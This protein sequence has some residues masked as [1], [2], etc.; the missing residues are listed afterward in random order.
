M[1]EFVCIDC[2][3]C[4][5]EFSTNED[6]QITTGIFVCSDCKENESKMKCDYCGGYFDEL[7]E[8]KWDLD[9]CDECTEAYADNESQ[10]RDEYLANRFVERGF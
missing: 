5:E 6:V 3:V 4:G 1:K 9:L 7:V 2:S 8:I 10:K